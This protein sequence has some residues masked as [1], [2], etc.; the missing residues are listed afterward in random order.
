MEE[1]LFARFQPSL[2]SID[3][4]VVAKY[5]LAPQNPPR[6]GGD[7]SATWDELPVDGV[8]SKPGVN[9]S[10]CAILFNRRLTRAEPLFELMQMKV[11]RGGEILEY[12]P[13]GRGGFCI[14]DRPRWAALAGQ[15][16]EHHQALGGACNIL[17]GW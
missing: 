7:P 6:A 3:I 10:L 1:I 15:Q 8:T 12:R 4:G 14:H 13:K 17:G 16:R 2:G 9:K 5:F 11:A